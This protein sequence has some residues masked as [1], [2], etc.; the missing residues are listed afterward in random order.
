M[1]GSGYTGEIIQAGERKCGIT[2]LPSRRCKIS[3]TG[4]QLTLPPLVRGVAGAVAGAPAL[5]TVMLSSSS[6]SRS[7]IQTHGTDG[8]LLVTVHYCQR[9]PLFTARHTRM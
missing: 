5:L 7:P 4:C 8:L 6:L 1:I 3:D 2:V 9:T